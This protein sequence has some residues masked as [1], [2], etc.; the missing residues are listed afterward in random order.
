MCGLIIT[1]ILRNHVY[2]WLL[3]RPSDL[4]LAV[5]CVYQSVKL[6]CHVIACTA[7]GLHCCGKA[8]RSW[9]LMKPIVFPN[10]GMTSGFQ[11]ASLLVV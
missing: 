2:S 8:C 5:S 10:G 3:Q 6:R 1:N 11:T 4:R 9:L 7:F